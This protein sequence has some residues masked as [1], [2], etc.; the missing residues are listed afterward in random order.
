MGNLEINCHKDSFS[1]FFFHFLL[2][3][4]GRLSARSTAA[5]LWVSPEVHNCSRRRR[6]IHLSIHRSTTPSIDIYYTHTASQKKISTFFFHSSTDIICPILLAFTSSNYRSWKFSIYRKR[7]NETFTSNFS[8]HFI[9]STMK[10]FLSL[11]K[12]QRKKNFQFF[13]LIQRNT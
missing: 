8:F 7:S 9:D 3:Y 2:I 4:F 12:L 13:S 1:L 5:V 10:Y 6:T 11:E